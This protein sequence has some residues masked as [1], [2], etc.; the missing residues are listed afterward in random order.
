LDKLPLALALAQTTQLL[1][2]DRQKV[3]FPIL[4]LLREEF[5]IGIARHRYSWLVN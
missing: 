5:I 3:N 2:S 4:F 1:G